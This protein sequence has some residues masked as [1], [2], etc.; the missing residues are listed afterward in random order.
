MRL[1][2]MSRTTLWRHIRD[3]NVPEPIRIGTTVRWHKIT[4]ENWMVEKEIDITAKP[5][6]P[7]R[8]LEEFA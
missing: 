1:L 5:I 6:K 4:F 3:G 8:D 2:K 7:R